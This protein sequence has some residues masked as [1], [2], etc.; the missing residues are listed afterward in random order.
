MASDPT[1]TDNSHILINVNLPSKSKRLKKSRNFFK[2]SV[3]NLG[4]VWYYNK[5]V[6]RQHSRTLK[7]EQ[8]RMLN[9]TFKVM[10]ND[11]KQFQKVI[12]GRKRIV[13]EKR[14]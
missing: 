1:R 9:G 8:Y 12:Q 2:K 5:A 7:I 3:D 14:D 11:Y 6:A 13:S 10:E 4:L